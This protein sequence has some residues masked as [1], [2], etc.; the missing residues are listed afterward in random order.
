MRFLFLSTFVLL[1][2]ISTTQVTA[3]PV[4]THLRARAGPLEFLADMADFLKTWIKPSGTLIQDYGFKFGNVSPRTFAFVRN[5]AFS[6][7][8]DS[9]L[10]KM[11]EGMDADT[12]TKIWNGQGTDKE[13]TYRNNIL[14]NGSKD[15]M[16]ARAKSVGDKTGSYKLITQYLQDPRKLTPAERETFDGLASDTGGFYYKDID[17]LYAQQ[18]VDPGTGIG[19]AKENADQIQKWIDD[20]TSPLHDA[21]VAARES[22]QQRAA[23]PG[24]P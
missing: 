8:A 10:R 12:L 2:A 1:L 24:S 15:P 14:K 5:L 4:S 18:A 6:Q 22:A 16:Y 11:V 17:T 3:A 7:P 9:E 20:P 23:T 13:F 19:L 21:A